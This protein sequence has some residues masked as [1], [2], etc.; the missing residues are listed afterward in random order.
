[1]ELTIGRLLFLAHRS[2]HDEL[3][4]RLREHGASLWTWVLLRE[5]AN[6]GE[7][8]QGIGDCPYAMRMPPKGLESPQPCFP[9][10]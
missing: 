9:L 5:A 4:R 2:V 1:M 3:D 10:L 8:R 7:E 6:A